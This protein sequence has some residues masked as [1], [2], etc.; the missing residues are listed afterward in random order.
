MYELYS[1]CIDRIPSEEQLDIGRIGAKANL[2]LRFPPW[3]TDEFYISVDSS[4]SIQPLSAQTVKGRGA[5]KLPR[6]VKSVQEK[7][8]AL[9]GEMSARE[10]CLGKNVQGKWSGEN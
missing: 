4:V 3:P 9:G 6:A 2:A 5:Y 10:K 8:E 1:L 7:F